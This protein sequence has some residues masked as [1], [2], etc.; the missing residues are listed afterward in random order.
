MS[1][2]LPGIVALLKGTHIIGLMVWVGGLMA[3]PL[4]LSR[5]DPAVTQDD[6]RIIRRATHLTYTGIVTPAA[7]I[8][9]VAGTWLIFFREVFVPWLYAKLVFV[10][11]LTAAHAWI[12]HLVMLVAEK[13]E[14]HR[15]PEPYLPLAAILCIVAVILT[16]VLGKPDLGWIEMPDWLL[17]PLGAQL[18][19]DVPSR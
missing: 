7:I 11:A 4:M 2:F 5:H 13:P 10:G 14:R 12:G 16:L 9:V 17:A 6:Y 19:F 8:T 18:P 3:L 1:D 15:P